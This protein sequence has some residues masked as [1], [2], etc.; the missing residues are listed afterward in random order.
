MDI[1]YRLLGSSLIP[2]FV[3]IAPVCYTKNIFNNTKGDDIDS[4]LSN[5]LW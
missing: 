1:H 4:Y 2:F 5:K 3:I